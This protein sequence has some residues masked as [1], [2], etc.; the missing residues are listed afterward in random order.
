MTLII[1][2]IVSKDTLFPSLRAKGFALLFFLL[3]EQAIDHE[4][5]QTSE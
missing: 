5:F 3:D 2:V 1:I 4:P